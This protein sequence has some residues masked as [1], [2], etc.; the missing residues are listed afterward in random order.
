MSELGVEFF[1]TFFYW[2]IMNQKFRR[3]IKILTLNVFSKLNNTIECEI[4]DE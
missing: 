2:K 4:D 1:C 3:D